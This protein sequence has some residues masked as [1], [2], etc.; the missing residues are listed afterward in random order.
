MENIEHS[1]RESAVFYSRYMFQEHLSERLFNS[2]RV[3][4]QSDFK[5]IRLIQR[6]VI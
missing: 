6:S 3:F 5:R 1:I 2:A 4:H